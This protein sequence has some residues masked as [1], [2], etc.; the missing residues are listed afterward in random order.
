M[1]K[2]VRNI[3]VCLLACI[4]LAGIA[5]NL[6]K[7]G[8][9]VSDHSPE[10][11][12]NRVIWNGRKYSPISGEYT[13][14]RTIAKGN[15]GDWVIN[16]VKEYPSHTFIVARSFLD[17]YLMVSDDYTIPTSGTL[18][19]AAWNGT[20]ITDPAFLD[21]LTKIQA[22]KTTS[23]SYETDNLTRPTDN[24][25]MRSRYFAYENCPVTTCFM[26]YMGQVNGQWVITTYV[27][28]DTRNGDG[29]PKPYTVNCYVVPNEYWDIL[30][31]YFS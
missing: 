15:S 19:T 17:Q 21:T 27:S 8:A 7:S 3:L 2:Y 18:T 16:M 9:F 12:A 1:K 11:S 23:F 4:V 29:S 20:Y 24:Q 26:G 14:G 28:Q 5:F 13:E 30:S 10:V 22:G 25:R 6:W 31:K